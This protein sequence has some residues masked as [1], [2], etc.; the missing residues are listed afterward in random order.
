MEN[1]V[2]VVIAAGTEEGGGVGV[3]EFDEVPG[4]EGAGVGEGGRG[5]DGEGEG[6]Q[7]RLRGVRQRWD[8]KR[9][10]G[11]GELGEWRRIFF[12]GI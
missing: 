5:E 1:F 6:G 7:G 10:E 12:G 3:E 4:E 9:R 2:G 8:C 11:G